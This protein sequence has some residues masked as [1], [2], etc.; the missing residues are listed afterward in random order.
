MIEIKPRMVDG[1]VLCDWG[2]P[3]RGTNRSTN[4]WC[5]TC[6]EGHPCHPHYRDALSAAE[7]EIEALEVRRTNARESA[8]VRGTALEKAEA[9]AEQAE[10]KLS[11]AQDSVSTYMD[12][13][14]MWKA[15][16]DEARAVI[17][18]VRGWMK[19]NE[20]R[21]IRCEWNDC[22]CLWCQIR[23]ILTT[24]SAEGEDD[25]G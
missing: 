1:E 24:D 18:A 17:A 16:Y 14:T 4:D 9:R 19:D 8:D 23:S 10:A 12:T 13:T 3:R 6:H 7:Q 21:G 11:T 22:A 5:Y 15:K 20:R 25:N 2:C